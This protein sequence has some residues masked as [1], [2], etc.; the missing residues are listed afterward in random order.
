MDEQLLQEIFARMFPEKAFAHEAISQKLESDA[1]QRQ[2][3]DALTQLLQENQDVFSAAQLSG[4]EKLIQGSPLAGLDE[5][6]LKEM[7]T[8]FQGFQS[9]RPR[10]G[11]F[12]SGVDELLRQVMVTIGSIDQMKLGESGGAIGGVR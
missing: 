12:G 2:L 8:F 1:K 5:E 3:A 10:E 6:K 4:D 9:S 7:M 11:V